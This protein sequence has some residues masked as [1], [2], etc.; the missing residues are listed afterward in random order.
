MDEGKRLNAY[1]RLETPEEQEEF[2]DFFEINE[3][4]QIVF[5]HYKEVAP[6]AFNETLKYYMDKRVPM[7]EID[8]KEFKFLMNGYLANIK[9][10]M[11][12]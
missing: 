9:Q 12:P 2:L 7:N 3:Q 1:Q 8:R 4:R 11:V 10:P 6:D 5:E